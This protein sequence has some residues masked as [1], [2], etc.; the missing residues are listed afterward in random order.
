M[1]LEASE[2]VEADFLTLDPGCLAVILFSKFES[3]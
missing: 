1:R 2:C 3:S